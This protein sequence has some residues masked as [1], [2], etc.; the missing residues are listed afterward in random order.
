VAYRERTRR[1]LRAAGLLLAV[2]GLAS[3]G[4]G[5]AAPALAPDVA[6]VPVAVGT[7]TPLPATGP[8]GGTVTLYG[9][10]TDSPGPNQN[11]LACTRQT[12]DGRT[13][14]AGLSEEGAAALERRVVNGRALLP[15]LQIRDAAPDQR[16]RCTGAGAYAVQP[17]YLLTTVGQRDLVPMAAFSFGTLA[18]ALGLAA[19]AGFRPIDS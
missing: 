4:F 15:L 13:S 19:V 18:V 7:A 10:A 6:P 9:A 3:F 16:I 12:A 11:L 14:R 1:Q 2:L 5:I 8:F 17:L